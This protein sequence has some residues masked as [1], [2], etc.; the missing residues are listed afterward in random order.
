MVLDS[1][2]VALLGLAGC[3]SS[4]TAAVDPLTGTWSNASGFGTITVLSSNI[5]GTY[6]Q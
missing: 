6:Q 2:L 1:S 4:S 5:A 3:G